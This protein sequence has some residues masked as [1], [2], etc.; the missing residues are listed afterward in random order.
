L[1]DSK[2]GIY[3]VYPMDFHKLIGYLKFAGN[4]AG[5]P[6]MYINGG[7]WSH[8]NTFYAL[9]L[10]EAGRTAEAVD[11]V[12]RIMTLDGILNSPNGQPAMY[13]YRIARKDSAAVYGKV[14]K[15]Q[16]MWA[17]GFYI[18][19][20]YHLFGIDE[21]TYN[22]RFTPYLMENQDK[23]MFTLNV[24]GSSPEVSI[25]GKGEYIKSIKYDGSSFPSAVIP[26]FTAAKKIDITL[27]KPEAPYLNSAGAV[28]KK[29]EYDKD[30][31]ELSLTL[32]SFS[33]HRD[34]LEVV[35]PLKP[36]EV[37]MNGAIVPKGYITEKKGE[38]YIMHFSFVPDTDTTEIKIRY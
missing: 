18:Y 12:K 16:F 29:A 23:C 11:F 37:S 31:R 10:K 9:A 15:P 27:G 3:T 5:D 14:D 26:G 8:G 25:S 17:A 1:L 38:V 30:K 7:V 36:K 21:G 22:I 24:P 13:E 6:Y 19:S 35:S 28:L 4:E 33:G 20:L 34:P 2:I 32:S